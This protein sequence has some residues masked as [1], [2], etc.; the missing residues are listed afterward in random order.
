MERESFENEEIAELLNR[1]FRLH[2]GGPRRAAGRGPHLHD[3]RAGHHGRRRLAHVGVA[4]AGPAAVLR[5]HLFPARRTATAIPASG[6]F[7]RRSPKPG[8]ATA[9]RSSNR[10]ETWSEQLEQA[11][12]CAAASPR[13]AGSG[14]AGERL[15]TSSGAL[16]IRSIGGFGGAPKFPRPVHSISCCATARAPKNAEALDMVLLTLREMAKGGMHDQ[17]GGGFHRYSV[18]DR[19]FVPHFEKMLYDQ[20]QLADLL[21]GSVPDHRRCAV[22]PTRRAAS[23]TT[24]CAT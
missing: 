19:W 18:D 23:S 21:P 11:D 12:G 5:R 20:A 7:W 2:Q 14:R 15:L 4:D 1:V 22:S 8:T 3:F 17:L 24:F 10:A 9:D 6:R 13:R 16:S